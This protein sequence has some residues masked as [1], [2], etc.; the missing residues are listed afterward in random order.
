MS[1]T[2]PDATLGVDLGGTK[3]LLVSGTHEARSPTGPAYAPRRLEAELRRFVARL[4]RPPRAIGIGVPGL[5]DPEGR[6][7][8]CDVLPAFAGWEA[9]AALA[10]LD[11]KVT[12]VNDVRAALED[13]FH[14]APPGI[15][16]CVVMAGTA[17]GAA[18]CVQG[19]PLGGARGLAGELG[20]LPVTIDG[21]LG[22]L[23]ELAGG[24]FIA[25]RA[26]VD[27]AE[28]ARRAMDGDRDVLTA[29]EAGGRALGLGLAAVI[30]LLNPSRLALGGGTLAL[31]GYASAARAEAERLSL[32][33]AWRDCTL[34]PVRSGERVVALGAARCAAT[35]A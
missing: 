33:E 27:A 7:L 15:T 1:S 2:P 12:V 13:E 28:L 20:Y 11:A 29:V 35:R 4:E 30:N 21:R 24:A 25:R 6:V 14:D 5:V 10:G 8:A 34:A 23:D 31:P 16:G 3:L 22:H 9:A 19:T 26:G 18:F 17:I 32:P